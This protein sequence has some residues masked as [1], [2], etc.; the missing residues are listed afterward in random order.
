MSAC[1]T[2]LG[3]LAAWM[4]AASLPCALAK[5]S[6]KAGDRPLA[7]GPRQFLVKLDANKNGRIDGPEVARLREAHAGAM[8]Q[9][10]SRFDL[11][12]DGRLDDREVAGIRIK[13]S[14]AAPRRPDGPSPSE[15]PVQ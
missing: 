13:S 9:E 11:N 10:L 4:V 6:S 15:A 8:Q 5:E 3:G 1:K 7:L 12:G 2:V 14:V